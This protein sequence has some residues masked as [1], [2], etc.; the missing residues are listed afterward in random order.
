MELN[1]TLSVSLAPAVVRDAFDD[2]AL[3]RAS[4]DHCES[5]A[6]L[7]DGEFALTITVPLG[8]LRARYDVRVH[9]AGEQGDAEGQPRRVLNFKARADGL[10]V[11][12]G[13]VELVLR[14][15]GDADATRIDYVVWA[16]ASGPL[17][18]LP[19]RQIENALREWTDDFFREFCAVVQAKHGL[20]PN[21]ARSAAPR[22]QHVFLRPA[23]LT[24]A[25]RRSPSPHLGGA[26]GGRAASALHHRE[27]GTVPVWAWA[28]MIVFVALLLYA[29]RW[30]NGG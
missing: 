16:T 11:L 29:A 18:E 22:R 10:G 9:V 25:T 26:L 23:A 20:A 27:P 17:A 21:R 6:K 24:A 5:F 12:R 7:A 15:D 8:P 14:P 2:L 30:F 1:D 4:F 19:A 28:A 13:Q 3:L